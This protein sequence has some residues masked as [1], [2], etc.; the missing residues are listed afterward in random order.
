MAGEGESELRAAREKGLGLD[1]LRA[2]S[3]DYSEVGDL[4]CEVSC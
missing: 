3:A 2:M 1:F 4:N